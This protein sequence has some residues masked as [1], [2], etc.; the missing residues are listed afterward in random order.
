[1]YQLFGWPM[2]E[3]RCLFIFS[4]RLLQMYKKFTCIYNQLTHT[5][6]AP[7]VQESA[8]TFVQV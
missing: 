6:T 8:A 3:L 7:D 1:M 2:S 5:P 4:V